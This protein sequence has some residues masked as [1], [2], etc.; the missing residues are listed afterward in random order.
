MLPLP[1]FGYAGVSD[2]GT[3]FVPAGAY[4]CVCHGEQVPCPILVL[5]EA[6]VGDSQDK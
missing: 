6:L 3:A 4:Y 2:P 1:Q 5:T